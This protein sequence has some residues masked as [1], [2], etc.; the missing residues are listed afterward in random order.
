MRPNK[1]KQTNIPTETLNKS[2][3]GQPLLSVNFEGD[4][5]TQPFRIVVY[6]WRKAVVG[7]ADTP[8]SKMPTEYVCQYQSRLDGSL[9]QETY[10]DLEE[11]T[12]SLCTRILRN[13]AFLDGGGDND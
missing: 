13:A 3:N 1:N 12:Q 2:T 7:S 4:E 10:G 11:C 5:F 9:F 6:P 8:G